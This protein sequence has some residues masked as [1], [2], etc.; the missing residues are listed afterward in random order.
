MEIWTYQP[1][2]ANHSYTWLAW[3]KSNHLSML[4]LVYHSFYYTTQCFLFNLFTLRIRIR[5]LRSL[6]H[7][8]KNLC[9]WS[10]AKYIYIMQN[11]NKSWLPGSVWV[12][13][14]TVHVQQRESKAMQL[15]SI[16][17]HHLVHLLHI[18]RQVCHIYLPWHSTECLPQ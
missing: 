12:F 18:T 10:P 9:Y 1:N 16:F 3:W 5:T 2:K 8:F 4:Q 15:S 13:Y 14:T 11:E 17:G 7:I 6:Y